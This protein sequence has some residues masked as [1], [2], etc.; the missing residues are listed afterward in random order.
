[1]CRKLCKHCCAAE[2]R[3]CTS[4]FVCSWLD[5]TTKSLMHG[6]GVEMILMWSLQQ[7]V[8][9]SRYSTAVHGR[10]RRCRDTRTALWLSTHTTRAAPFFWRAV[11]RYMLNMHWARSPQHNKYCWC[12]D[13]D[14]QIMRYAIYC[15]YLL[16]HSCFFS[17]LTPLV[18]WQ[19]GYLLC[20]KISFQQ[21]PEVFLRKANGGSSVSFWDKDKSLT[22][23]SYQDRI[24]DRDC[25]VCL[26][27]TYY[28]WSVFMY[29]HCSY[30]TN[31][32]SSVPWKWSHISVQC[33]DAI[34]WVTGRPLGL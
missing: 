22:K 8:L 3:C 24:Q 12:H 4:G 10:A 14:W 15:L 11:Q 26:F 25:D 16:I 27:N 31:K 6:S 34:G 2:R 13:V 33:F 19:E 7:T 28:N 21:S 29:I 5:I 17:A 9:Y 1:M 23:L 32:L 20:K 18:G 30:L